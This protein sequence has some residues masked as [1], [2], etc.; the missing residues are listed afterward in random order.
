MRPVSLT[1]IENIDLPIVA[2]L[3]QLLAALA[4]SNEVVLQAEPGAGKTSLVPLALLA[5]SW[6]QNQKI[7][8]L[9][10]RRL[11]ARSAAERMA[12]LL[13]EPV[14]KTVGYRIRLDSNVSA[15]TQ[16]EVITEG[17]LTRMLHTDPSLE[18]VGVVIF[19]EF[20][21]R[22]LDAD[23]GLALTLQ[24]RKL[25]RDKSE[26]EE[27]LKIV[28]MSATL[29]G[30]AVANMIGE[31]STAPII[32]SEGRQYPV[33]IH[34]GKQVTLSED[35]VPSVVNTLL[36]VVKS[37]QGSVLVFLPGQGEIRRVQKSLQEQLTDENIL[38]APLYGELSLKEQRLAIAPLT[39]SETVTRKIVLATAIAESSLTIDGVTVVVDSGLTRFPM[40]DPNTG[41]TRLHTGRV[42]KASS[43]QRMGRA[44][45]LQAGSCY[46][47]WSESQQQQLLPQSPAEILQADLAPLAMQLLNWGVNDATELEWLDMPPNAPYM[48]AL[49]LL[50][51]LAAIKKVAANWQLTAHGEAM[52]TLPLH[53]RLA[54]MLLVGEQYGLRNLACDIASVLSDRDP[55]SHTRRAELSDRLNLFYEKQSSSQ[56]KRLRQQSLN[57][58]RLCVKLTITEDRKTEV[59]ADQQLG[60]LL[61]SAYPDRIAKRRSANAFEYLLSN[62][63][64]AKLTDTDN[65]QRAEWLVVAN[66][67]GRHGQS[68]D[69]IFLATELD[70]RLF[71]SALAGQI[72]EQDV[73]EWDLKSEKFRAETRCCV[74]GLVVSRKP[75]A[76]IPAMAKQKILIEQ[77]QNRG[78]DC[79]P[80]TDELRQWQARILLLRKLDI[81]QLNDSQW[82]DVSDEHLLATLPEWLGPYLNK[83]NNL[84]H[85]QK[86][87]LNNILPSLLS[88]PLPKTLNEDAPIR[89]AVPSGSN[90]TIDYRSNPP[91]LSVKLQEMFGCD[92]TPRIA[93]GRQPLMVH[94]LSPARRPL[95]VTQDLASF[96]QNAYAAVKKDMKGRYPKHPWPDS[97]LDAVATARVKSRK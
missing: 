66:L 4:E 31:Y 40:F 48:Q 56:I 45:R 97:P 88:W 8:V 84:A 46:R 36:Q 25:F 34:Y 93:A 79:L 49:E 37:E 77:I 51:R 39:G 85:L 9:E 17:I 65:L 26:G 55:L 62:G 60:L 47:L 57:Y 73:V 22:N 95:A 21:E 89:M 63:R 59:L 28:V 43:V 24:S 74:G 23:L 27:S 15:A 7:L 44:G 13:G 52:A 29:D 42:S 64:A 90:L 41:M 80:W 18:G 14:G 68:S 91:V 11:A 69:Q 81:E 12:S 6:L 70:C 50:Q 16:I 2:C 67:G 61:A 35:I 30:I 82:P 75:L 1:T 78:L 3:P 5:E 38:I 86:L 32:S 19:D 20:H 83:V 96:W 54:H 10:P 92:T 53:P 58:Q 72:T 76:T 71:K 94:L 87:D 33:A